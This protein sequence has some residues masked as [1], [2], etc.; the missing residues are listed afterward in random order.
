MTKDSHFADRRDHE[1]IAAILHN[2]AENETGLTDVQSRR[3]RRLASYVEAAH[4]NAL[5][6][7]N[8]LFWIRKILRRE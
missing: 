1:E 5:D 2:R 6:A 4:V 8:R 7:S 3:L